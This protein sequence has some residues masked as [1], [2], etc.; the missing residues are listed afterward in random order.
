MIEKWNSD[1]SDEEDKQNANEEED[2]P[3]NSRYRDNRDDNQDVEEDRRDTSDSEDETAYE[4][5][6]DDIPVSKNGEI[7]RR[8][9]VKSYEDGNQLNVSVTSN[10]SHARSLRPLEEHNPVNRS[11]SSTSSRPSQSR[12]TYTAEEESQ[13]PLSNITSSSQVQQSRRRD[14]DEEEDS[15]PNRSITSSSSQVLQSKKSRVNEYESQ[16]SLT[17]NITQEKE[18]RRNKRIIS[19][20]S[21]PTQS[22]YANTQPTNLQKNP[23]K[24]QSK[25]NPTPTLSNKTTQ[26]L[27]I[28]RVPVINQQPI[29]SQS[30]EIPDSQLFTIEER[31]DES[32]SDAADRMMAET[33]SE[34]QIF[35]RRMALLNPTHEENIITEDSQLANMEE[36]ICSPILPRKPSNRS[37]FLN[38]NVVQATHRSVTRS[39][40]SAMKTKKKTMTEAEE[41]AMDIYASFKRTTKRRK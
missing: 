25:S 30:D 27:E 22:T 13:P 23:K 26:P 6:D 10:S 3:N 34:I 5:S 16:P 29:T 19:D 35:K 21:Q 32:T 18:S 31:L 41:D 8:G 24:T 14:R 39:Q 28:R 2:D 20:D 4:K 17:S 36:D 40:E 1:V 12:R 9:S 37:P 7:M 11:T 15:Q 33:L 38:R